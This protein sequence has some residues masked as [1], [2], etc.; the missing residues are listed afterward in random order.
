MKSLFIT[1][2][3]LS[4]FVAQ[5][6]PMKGSFLIGGNTSYSTEKQ[7]TSLYFFGFSGGTIEEANVK[8]GSFAVTPTVGYFI[9]DNLCV[10]F[11]F[12]FSI[13]KSKA[14]Q[15][16]DV[17][18]SYEHETRSANF[19]PFV[20]YYIPLQSNLYLLTGAG[21]GWGYARETYDYFHSE[22]GVI[23]VMHTGG[24]AKFKRFNAGVGVSYFL[25][26]NMGLEL[27]AAYNSTS[28]E[29]A[30]DNVTGIVLAA[31]LQM[32]LHR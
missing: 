30:D 29:G 18:F 19:A 20:R 1:V 23:N 3:T 13:T 6:Q 10:G 9:I 25:N 32:Y 26:K 17:D 24:K 28:Y 2:L 12:P 27:L 4:A 8:T 21:Y 31:G 5:S 15:R 22:N 14:K 7:K 11:S 16:G